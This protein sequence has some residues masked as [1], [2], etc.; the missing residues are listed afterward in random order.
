M[1]PAPEDDPARGERAH[2]PAAPHVRFQQTRDD[3]GGALA[4]DRLRPEQ[5]TLVGG[6]RLDR[7]LAPVEAEVVG[8]LRLP[9]EPLLD[10]LREPVG[11]LAQL[12]R[13]SS[14]VER[15]LVAI[16]NSAFE[17]S[18]LTMASPESFQLWL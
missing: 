5:V 4:A 9:P 6:D 16:G 15:L 17:P 10:H 18:A 14:V 3:A 11:L 13:A 1:A 7:S 2:A 12:R 8:A